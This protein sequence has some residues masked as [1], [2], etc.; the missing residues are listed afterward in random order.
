MVDDSCEGVL[1]V[2]GEGVAVEA[3]VRQVGAE[4]VEVWYHAAEEAGDLGGGAHWQGA[5]ELAVLGQFEQLWFLFLGFLH[6]FCINF[7]GLWYGSV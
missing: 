2:A 7:M 3:G 1:E 4:E 6:Y 5:E